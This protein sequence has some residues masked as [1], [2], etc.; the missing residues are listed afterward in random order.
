MS[1]DQAPENAF[2]PFLLSFNKISEKI[3]ETIQTSLCTWLVHSFSRVFAQIMPQVTL[4]LANNIDFL[5][6]Q[7][8]SIFVFKKAET[9]FQTIPCIIFL[10]R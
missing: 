7:N 2:P 4:K 1:E 8:L 10:L 3:S 5:S 9:L 6:F